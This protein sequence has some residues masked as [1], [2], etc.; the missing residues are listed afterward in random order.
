MHTGAWPQWPPHLVR[1]MQDEL[2]WRAH[3]VLAQIFIEE[4]R[5]ETPAV[6][7]RV[8]RD[9]S[10]LQTSA[11]DGC[12]RWWGVGSGSV[13][14]SGPHELSRRIMER[15]SMISFDASKPEQGGEA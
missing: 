2:G 8:M 4:T 10:T 5:T 14:H 13:D 11:E 1:R 3:G 6:R 7:I 15:M 12:V 9:M